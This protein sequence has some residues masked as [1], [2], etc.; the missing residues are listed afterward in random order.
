MTDTTHTDELRAHHIKCWPEA[1]EEIRARRKTAE[2]RLN[3]RDY[4]AG[5]TLL[6]REWDPDRKEYTHRELSRTISHVLKDGFGM[7]TGYAMLSLTEST[8]PLST[9]MQTG[10]GAFH[11][12]AESLKVE[13]VST[14]P[15]P[16]EEGAREDSAYQHQARRKH[17]G[18]P[19]GYDCNMPEGCLVEPV[20][21][22][23]AVARAARDFCAELCEDS[24]D[25]PQPQLKALHAA[26]E[27]WEA[28]LARQYTE[29]AIADVAAERRRQIEAEGWTPEHDD[30]HGAGELAAAAAAYAFSA[31][32]EGRYL[33]ADP[34]GF[35]PWDTSWW[36]PRG[37]RRDLVRAGALIVAEIERIDRAALSLPASTQEKG[38]G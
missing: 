6:I 2:F 21:P 23:T 19:C 24:P 3:D 22:A 25:V 27:A 14:P 36:K 11:E 33:A 12:T 18:R 7:P 1:F 26:L 4:R 9:D 15:E 31:A 38:N 29:G 13:E 28:S 5:D 20:D 17:C 35:W 30:E 10:R 8:T 34:L 32:T 37:A 16:S